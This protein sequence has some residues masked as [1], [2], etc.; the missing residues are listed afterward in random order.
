MLQ[1]VH[2]LVTVLSPVTD[3]ITYLWLERVGSRPHPHSPT[4]WRKATLTH[5]SVNCPVRADHRE[6]TEGSIR[7][8]VIES[9]DLEYW[10]K[11]FFC[12]SSGFQFFGF[13]KMEEEPN[14]V[15]HSC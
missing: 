2:P 9:G 8:G 10:I 5:P 1:L 15:K 14:E 4:S 12:N 7:V 3:W 11:K 13:K 6:A